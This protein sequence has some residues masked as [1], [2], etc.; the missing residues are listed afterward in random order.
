M[1]EDEV[2][3]RYSTPGLRKHELSRSAKKDHLNGLKF[4]REDR[5]KV[6]D[7]L[8]GPELETP[9]GSHNKEEE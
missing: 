2:L 8:Y 7:E 9:E 1:T 4:S 5:D 3:A 6:L